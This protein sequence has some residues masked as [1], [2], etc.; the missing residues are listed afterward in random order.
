MEGMALRITARHDVSAELTRVRLW[1]G[2]T[3]DWSVPCPSLEVRTLRD[4]ACNLSI[5]QYLFPIAEFAWKIYIL[6]V[7]L[8][9]A[10]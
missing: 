7:G 5:G 2:E 8:P 10:N 3:L 4:N 1:L 6:N 9:V